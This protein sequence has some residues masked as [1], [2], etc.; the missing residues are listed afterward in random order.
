MVPVFGITADYD[1]APEVD[2]LATASSRHRRLGRG[3]L[4]PPANPTA[5][6]REAVAQPARMIAQ[7]TYD[8]IGAAHKALEE[9][10]HSSGCRMVGPTNRDLPGSAGH[11][12]RPHDLLTEVGVPVTTDAEERQPC[13]RRN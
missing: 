13:A 2:L 4:N 9:W 10:I 1:S 11:R 6:H 8:R 5:R 12:D 7:E 3:R